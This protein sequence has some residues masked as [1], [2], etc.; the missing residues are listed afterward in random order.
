MGGAVWGRRL[1][2]VEPC[3]DERVVGT[4]VHEI[5]RADGR[6]TNNRWLYYLLR[7][8]ATGWPLR[9]PAD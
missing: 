5:Q 6:G 2:E 1:T 4:L 9:D 8:I 3:I 7:R